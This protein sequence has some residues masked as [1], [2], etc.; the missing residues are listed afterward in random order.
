MAES[1]ELDLARS[2]SL[3]VVAR[4]KVLRASRTLRST[5]PTSRAAE[6]GLALGC[7]WVLTGTC[8]RLGPALRVTFHL[9][10]AATSHSIAV[11]TVDGTLDRIFE[12]QDQIAV[13]TRARLTVETSAEHSV[14]RLYDI[15][16]VRVLCAWSAIGDQTREGVLRPGARAVRTSGSTGSTTCQGARRS[17]EHF[18]VTAH[19][20]DRV[21]RFSRGRC[22]LPG[23][24]PRLIRL[25]PSRTSGLGMR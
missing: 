18:C 16:C 17:R 20:H 8:R 6:L 9:V 15:V 13:T 22:P 10:E 19:V 1:L 12:I 5:D 21:R 11:E 2:S 7:R 23:A 25:W 4:D 24:P 3:T 14:Q